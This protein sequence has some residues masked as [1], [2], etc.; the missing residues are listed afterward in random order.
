MVAVTQPTGPQAT[1][2]T[3]TSGTK[4][5]VA[6]VHSEF[7][8]IR[9]VRAPY[10]TLIALIV[11]SVGLSCLVSWVVASHWATASASSKVGFDPTSVSLVGFIFGQ[12]FIAVFGVLALTGEYATGMITATLAAQPRRIDVYAAK[13]LV[14]AALAFVTG[15][16]AGFVAFFACQAILAS[17]HASAKI[18]DPGVLRSVIGCG[19]FL[20]VCALFSFAIA[21]LLRS[22]AGGIST[23]IGALLIVP[24]LVMVLPNSLSQDITRWLPSEAG[25]AILAPVTQSHEFSAWAGFGLFCAYTAILLGAGLILFNQRDS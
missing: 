17:T 5:M 11:L 6:L 3:R 25:S 10:M 9:T 1:G 2:L 21:A 22:A 18:G 19:L 16:L 13:A 12:M 7:T 8:K 4:R 14:V 15:L 23:A 24:L 20:A